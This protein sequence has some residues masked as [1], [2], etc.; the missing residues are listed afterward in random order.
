M[1]STAQGSGLA[2]TTCLT[3]VWEI[4][5]LNLTV[6]SCVIMTILGIGCMLLLKCLG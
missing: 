5:G 1:A 6:G 2:A 4:P 3:A